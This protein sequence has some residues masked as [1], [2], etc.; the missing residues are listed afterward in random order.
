MRKLISIFVLLLAATGS[1]LQI[2][3]DS[4][5]Q[6]NRI[7]ALENA[8]NQALQQKDGA[9]LKMLLAPELVFVDYDG[10]L[11]DKAQYLATVQNSSLHPVHLVSESMSV[12]F[13][14]GVAVVSGLCR[15]SGMKNGKPYSVRVRFT[16]TW[17]RRSESWVCV[18]SQSTLTS[19]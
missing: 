13:F 14:G 8:W 2:G 10:I 1:A 6:Q 16:D 7:V 17:V 18:A 12:R 4:D 3:S 19:Q 15:E 11:L 5:P 9:A